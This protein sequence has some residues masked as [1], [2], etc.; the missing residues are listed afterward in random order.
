[1]LKDKAKLDKILAK[2]GAYAELQD[3][4]ATS[5]F[6]AG[7]VQVSIFGNLGEHSFA[8]AYQV[9]NTMD[10]G[11]MSSQ[12]AANWASGGLDSLSEF[13]VNCGY[14]S[15]ADDEHHEELYAIAKYV[16]DAHGV[17]DIFDAYLRDEMTGA[18]E[19]QHNAMDANSEVFV[20]NRNSNN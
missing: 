13:L 3:F 20:L 11:S 5:E 2:A 10:C 9:S 18:W 16:G 12:L 14:E 19:Q 1:M 17:Q 8:V 15:L 4:N 7:A 6:N